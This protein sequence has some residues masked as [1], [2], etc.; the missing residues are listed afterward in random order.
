MKNPGYGP[1]IRILTVVCRSFGKQYDRAVLSAKT[2]FKLEKQGLNTEIYHSLLFFVDCERS[3]AY[4]CGRK[5]LKLAYLE[6]QSGILRRHL[7][8]LPALVFC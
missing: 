6:L 3:T 7:G 1:E 2:P 5:E 8:N 4:F